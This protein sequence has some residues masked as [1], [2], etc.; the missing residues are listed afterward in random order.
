MA[1]KKLWCHRCQDDT[2][3]EREKVTLTAKDGSRVEGVTITCR[4]CR[5]RRKAA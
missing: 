4:R 1:K 3:Y 5:A 2:E